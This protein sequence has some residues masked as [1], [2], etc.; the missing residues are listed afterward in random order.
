V[1]FNRANALSLREYVALLEIESEHGEI[2]CRATFKV[3]TSGSLSFETI[4]LF[5]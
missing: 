3:V 5:V 4:L 1:D 2:N